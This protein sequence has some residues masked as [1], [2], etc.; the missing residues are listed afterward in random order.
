MCAFSSHTTAIEQVGHVGLSGSSVG[1][2]TRGLECEAMGGVREVM[3]R[4]KRQEGEHGARRHER[5]LPVVK[6]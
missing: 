2:G 1:G 3:S 4:R 6:R 5:Q